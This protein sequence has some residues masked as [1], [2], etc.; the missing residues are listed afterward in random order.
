MTIIT[1][2]RGTFSGGKIL[3]ELL[4]GRLGYP[5]LSRE[6][7]VNHAA[8]EYGITKED[9]SR[10]FR[11]PSQLWEQAPGKRMA[12]LK[13]VT[14]TILRY[15]EKGRL[16]YHGHAGHLLLRG[17]SHVLRVRVLANREFRIE[18]AMER[19]GVT[20]DEAIAHIERIDNERRKWSRF[21][22][23]IDW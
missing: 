14:A 19:L 15:A 4:A 1:I 16:V 6:E 22:Y 3:A 20:R 10:A 8:E 21:L 13:C 17:I 23:G 2:S 11:E 18:A 5:C 9:L 7:A 12:Y